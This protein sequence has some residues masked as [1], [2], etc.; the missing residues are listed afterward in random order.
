MI[1]LFK[2]HMSKT[3]DKPLLKTLHSG[4]VG[5]GQKVAEFEKTMGEYVGN[6]K[7]FALSSATHGLHLALRLAGIGP[8]DDVIT[9]PLTCA[10]TVWPILYQGANIVWADIKTDDLNIDPVSV[11]QR[12]TER[13]KAI[14][15]V[16]WGGYPCDLEE[17]GKI[18]KENNLVLIEDA[19]QAL[20]ATYKKTKI[21]DCEYSDAAVVSFQ[22]IKALNTVDGGM[23]F[24]SREDFERRGHLMSWF[25]IDRHGHRKDLRCAVDIKEYG[26]KYHMND[27]A[28]LIGLENL[29]EL[30]RNLKTAREND[31]YYRENLKNVP[32]L[33]LLQNGEDRQSSCWLF[34]VLVEGHSSFFWKMGERG[35]MVSKVHT[36]NDL[37]SCV[38]Q[39]RRNDLTGLEMV[40]ESIACLPVGWWVTKEDR[41][42]IVDTIKGGW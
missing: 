41:E 38:S 7:C 30:D 28:A 18:A 16:H 8:G 10:A 3:V 35:I 37:H 34:T 6:P 21:G 31:R 32:G 14:L 11:K 22:A 36:R 26:Y 15:A 25:G 40:N 17:L 12:I 27:V 5:E 39:F 24:T 19:A 33:T 2:V 13:T 1:P 42:Y 29:K 23:L 4:W 9:T 20:G